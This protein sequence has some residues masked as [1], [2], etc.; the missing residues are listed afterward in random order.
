M[1]KVSKS[2]PAT[3]D[4]NNEMF[5]AEKIV[6]KRERNGREEYQV[7]WGGY[8]MEDCTWE[9]EEHLMNTTLISDYEKSLRKTKVNLTTTTE[10]TSRIQKRTT[11]NLSATPKTTAKVQRRANDNSFSLTPTTVS[12]IRAIEDDISECSD[13]E[14]PEFKISRLMESQDN[15]KKYTAK[16]IYGICGVLHKGGVIVYSTILSNNKL[17]FLTAE[18]V[19]KECHYMIVDMIPYVSC[20]AKQP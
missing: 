11:L 17:V 13:D 5:V 19:P 4:K 1:V 10:R 15:S 12:I 3:A 14:E 6:D 2:K 20:C 9:P 18:Q 16:D 8:S 7:K